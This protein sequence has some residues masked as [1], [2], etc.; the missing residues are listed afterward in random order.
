MP[1]GRA[2]FVSGSWIFFGWCFGTF[3]NLWQ[4]VW[5]EDVFGNGWEWIQQLSEFTQ[6]DVSVWELQLQ[7]GMPPLPFT[8]QNS[9]D[10]RSSMHACWMCTS[11]VYLP[12]FPVW[13]KELSA[14]AVKLSFLGVCFCLDAG[15]G[16]ADPNDAREPD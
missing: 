10:R 13:K 3:L 15:R 6:L 9:W 2:A 12:R 14:C 1:F 4:R 7:F 16:E 11:T 5:R 8:R